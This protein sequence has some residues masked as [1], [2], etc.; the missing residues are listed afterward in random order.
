MVGLLG[1]GLMN[2]R[3]S[4]CRATNPLI[5]CLECKTRGHLGLAIGATCQPTP[6]FPLYENP[7]PPLCWGPRR[8]ASPGRGG[9]RSVRKC[10]PPNTA[11]AV[12]LLSV[13][14]IRRA[15]C[16]CGKHSALPTCTCSMTSLLRRHGHSHNL[17]FNCILWRS[18]ESFGI[19]RSCCVRAGAKTASGIQEAGIAKSGN[20][21][22]KSEADMRLFTLIRIV[23]VTVKHGI[24]RIGIVLGWRCAEATSLKLQDATWNSEAA[25]LGATTGKSSDGGSVD[26]DQLA[27]LSSLQSNGMRTPCETIS[28]RRDLCDFLSVVNS[29]I[30]RI[31]SVAKHI[32]RLCGFFGRD[33]QCPFLCFWHIWHIFSFAVIHPEFWQHTSLLKLQKSHLTSTLRCPLPYMPTTQT[34]FGTGSLCYMALAPEPVIL[35]RRTQ[36]CRSSQSLFARLSGLAPEFAGAVKMTI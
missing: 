7:S 33:A 15:G 17:H 2:L 27:S 24:G 8:G 28:M 4:T 36:L 32:T 14:V 22:R 5:F 1:P 13:S 29:L 35:L 19:I 31:R 23:R 9:S 34:S 11:G 30:F 12:S 21:L 3:A 10:D 18:Y 6:P 20:P 26:S 25:K 16:R